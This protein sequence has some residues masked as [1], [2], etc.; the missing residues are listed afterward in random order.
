MSQRNLF[1]KG[2]LP[3]RLRGDFEAFWKA[4]PPRSPNPRKLAEAAFVKTVVAGTSPAD[5]VA[6]AGAYA[7]E[8]KRKG[9]AE[10]FIVHA[11]TFLT[12]QRFA[13]YVPKPDAAPVAMDTTRAIEHPLWPAMASRID[14]R[15]FCRWIEPLAVVTHSEGEAAL[16]QAPSRFH[17][18]WVRQHYAVPL[19]TALRV[20]ILEIDVAEDIRA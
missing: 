12:Q 3:D 20:R 14:A 4:Y 13:D 15:A 16:L 6:A 7:A 11:R 17:R 10:D 18:D 9:V 2:G 8:V 1:P 5:L 19:K